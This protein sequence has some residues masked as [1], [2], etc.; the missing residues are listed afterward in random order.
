VAHGL[1]VTIID[2]SSG[3]RTVRSFRKSSV[4]IGRNPL[5]DLHVEQPFVSQFH[6]VVE[7]EGTGLVLRDLGS[8]NGSMVEGKK[9]SGTSIVLPAVQPAFSVL[10][11]TF[12]V[13]V[14]PL[15]LVPQSKK[16]PMAV[17]GLLQKPPADFLA[18]L[19]AGL[20]VDPDEQAR[21]RQLYEAYRST[22]ATLM[23]AMQEAALARPPAQRTGF[24]SQLSS[25]LP[26]VS[27]E[28]DY[29]RL[30]ADAGCNGIT[31]RNG[32]AEERIAAEGLR[33]FAMEF[34]PSVP[35]PESGDEIVKFLTRLRE[36]LDVFFKA[37]VP[38]RDGHRQ[39][40]TD[41]GI[42]AQAHGRADVVERAASPQELS[43]ALLDPRNSADVLGYVES[44]FAD[45][46]IHHVAM[47]NGVMTGVKG[48]LQELSPETIK[49]GAEKGGGREYFGLGGPG[50]KQYW[51][52]YQ[53]RYGDVA[54]EEKR[55]FKLLFGRQFSV[56]YSQAASENRTS[57][58][59]RIS[60]PSVTDPPPGLLPT[61]DGPKTS[62]RPPGRS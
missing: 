11:L 53:K 48:L 58:S 22:W 56:A 2:A 12:Q 31:M 43:A 50:P 16:R 25:D 28:P 38:L 23:N 10:Q 59:D 54:E 37:F 32:A 44:T 39:F 27:M 21:L 13:R 45:M 55:L 33:E 62:G 1:E 5:N 8:T 20:Q 42:P 29:H 46:M 34:M 14:V 52:E 15:E 40:R 30:A 17:T 6:A 47:L 49:E 26:A 19:R 7:S 9:L 36:T 57:S 4:R 18:G 61:L 24:V 41:L 60:R 51:Q 35:P 3:T